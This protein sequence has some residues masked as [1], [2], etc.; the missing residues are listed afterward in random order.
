MKRVEKLLLQNTA[1]NCELCNSE[2]NLSF[3]EVSGAP[4][5]MDDSVLTCQ[6]CKNQ[7][8]GTDTM[9]SNH[10]RCLN[11]SMWSEVPAV[12]V[13]A[14]RVLNQ[15]KHEVWPIDLFEMLYLDDVSLDWAKKGGV[16]TLEDSIKHKDSNGNVLA[17]GDS[18]SIIKDLNVKGANF[19]AKRGTTVRNIVLLNDN[20][21]QIEGRVNGQQIVI[22]TQYVKKVN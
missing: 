3:Y 8:D 16:D 1:S 2:I 18:V 7:L 17:T 4:N 15:L 11:E 5:G 14:W 13:L 6:I 21:E 9:D 10:W 22:L 12:Q 20:A 19:T